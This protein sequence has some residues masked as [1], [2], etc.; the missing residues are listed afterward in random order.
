M[1]V[2]S[3]TMSYVDTTHIHPHPSIHSFILPSPTLAVPVPSAS[4]APSFLLLL[5]FSHLVAGWL[6]PPQILCGYDATTKEFDVCDPAAAG[7][8]ATSATLLARRAAAAGAGA[9]AAAPS[10]SSSSS[11]PAAG[12]GTIA[13]AGGSG[14]HT[15]C[16]S[17][18]GLGMHPVPRYTL[19]EAQLETARKSF[20][21]D[22]DILIL[23]HRLLDN[24]E[25]PQPQ[26]AAAAALHVHVLK[27]EEQEQAGAGAAATRLPLPA[28]G[29]GGG[30]TA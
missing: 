20:G 26:P 12:A 4:F 3:D 16:G 23:K 15:R 11:S 10:S 18:S 25:Q 6:L 27:E 28:G 2:L 24:M 13:I 21:T 17:G 22:E 19:T 5:L 9:G 14:T 7:P 30:G 1:V 29:G 8:S